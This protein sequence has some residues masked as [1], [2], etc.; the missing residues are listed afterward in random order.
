M[1]LLE[2]SSVGANLGWVETPPWLVWLFATVFE[3]P[4]W[5]VGNCWQ[6]TLQL[7]KERSLFANNRQSSEKPK[8]A[9]LTCHFFPQ[10]LPT[11]FSHWVHPMLSVQEIFLRHP[12]IWLTWVES[13]LCILAC[14]YAGASLLV[15]PCPDPLLAFLARHMLCPLALWLWR[16]SVRRAGMEEAALQPGTASWGTDGALVWACLPTGEN[17]P[18]SH[19]PDTWRTNPG[20]DHALPRPGGRAP[21]LSGDHLILSNQTFLEFP[22]LSGLLLVTS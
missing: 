12:L 13:G 14:A 17:L 10:H 1:R 22:S 11:I 21:R 6:F 19:C 9:M 18:P 20:S 3:T 4:L 8:F 2:V 15:H 5:L 16:N 7:Q